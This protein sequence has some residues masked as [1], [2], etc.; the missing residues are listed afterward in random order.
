MSLSVKY[1]GLDLKNPI[2]IGSS[3]LT[4]SVDRI[5]KLEKNGAGAIVLKS[6]FEEQI[7]MDM[8]RSENQD[9][10]YHPEA[11]DY[12]RYYTKEKNT[13]DY[14]NLIK[15]AKESVNIPV[16]ASI[17]CVSNYEWSSFAKKIESAGADALEINVSMLPSDIKVNSTE[18][19]KK[20][21]DIISEVRKNIKIPIALKMSSYS[22]GL[23][24]LIQKLSWTKNIDAF[25]LFN[26]YYSPDID[27]DKMKIVSSNV[28]SSPA[29]ISVSL[30]WIALLS[31]NIKLPL[32][33]T[34][35]IHDSEGVVK[36]ILA[37]AQ[38]V[39][40]V[41]TIYKNGNKYIGEIIT[42]LE[43]WMN[44]N[45]Y[46]SLADFRGLLSYDKAKD[47][48]SFERIQFMKYYSNIN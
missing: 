1:L 11:H 24:Q 19:E 2:I 16:I 5:V 22:A 44:K 46:S 42:G 34:T 35:G 43:N 20:Y 17:N 15:E 21:F 12:A 8:G 33:A 45:N 32:V 48:A 27:L 7:L 18:N 40:I 39:Q 38:A 9:Y 29:E 13:S 4:G 10:H 23:A 6:L 47:A 36:Q 28:L 26:R 3:G 14:L 25:V 31:N 41:S 30:R 37:G